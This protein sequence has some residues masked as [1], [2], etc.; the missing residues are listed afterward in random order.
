MKAPQMAVGCLGLTLALLIAFAPRAHAAAA[1]SDTPCNTSSAIANGLNTGTGFAAWTNVSG[2]FY[3]GG[4]GISGDACTSHDWGMFDSGGLTTCSRPLTAANGTNILQVGQTITNDMENGG[5]TTG[6]TEGLSLWNASGQNV[7]EMYFVGGGSFWTVVDG[8]GTLTT[9]SIPYAGSGCR[10]IFTL[11]SPTTYSL[12]VNVPVGSTKYGPFTGSL[13]SPSGGQG[14]TQMRWFTSNIGG[15][16]NL[17]VGQMNVTCPDKLSFT[18]QPVS[19]IVPTNEAALFSADNVGDSVTYQWQSSSSSN[20]TYSAI[21]GG[22]NSYSLTATNYESGLAV[23]ATTANNNNWYRCVATDACGNTATSGAAQLILSSITTPGITSQP[24][25]TTVCSNSPATF[26]VTAAGSSPGYS[27][28]QQSNAGWGSG[29]A[30][31]V[32]ASNAGSGVFLGTSTNNETSVSSFCTGFGNNDIDSPISGNALGLFGP[33]IKV[34]RNFPS[35]LSAGQWF[36]IDMDNGA[37]DTGAQN[38][39][40]LHAGP[41]NTNSILFS[42]Y[43]LG[44]QLNYKIFDGTGE[45]DTGIRFTRTGLRVQVLVGSAVGGTN[46]YSLFVLTNQCSASSNIT[47]VFSGLF[48]TN[49]T[50]GSVLLYNNDAAGGSANDLFFNNL[51]AGATYDNADNYSARNWAN[52]GNGGDLPI[53]GAN[54]SSYTINNAQS[55]NVAYYVIVTNAAAAVVSSA[56]T[57]TINGN[58]TITTSSPLTAGS[59]NVSYSQTLAASGGTSPY[60]WTQTGGTLPTGLLLG[61]NGVL[62]GTPTVPGLY[63]FMVQAQDNSSTHCTVSKNFTLIIACNVTITISPTS[64]TPTVGASYS[65]QLTASAGQSPYTYTITSGS[66]PTGL[67]MTSGGLITGTTVSDTNVSFSVTALDANGCSGIQSYNVAPGCPTIS[68]SPGGSNP[69][70]LT[71]GTAAA[72]YSQTITASGAN[73][74]FTYSK[75]AGALPT[76]LTLSSAGVLSGTPTVSGVYTFTVTATD[77]SGCTGSQNY[78]LTINCPT[79]SLSPGGSNPQVLTAGTVGTSYTQT[80]TASGAENSFTFSKTSGTL[81]TGLSLSSAGVLS[82]TPTASGTYTFT[83]TA[84]DSSGCTGTQNYSLTMNCPIITVSPATLPN[85]VFNATYSTNLTATGG[86]GSIAFVVGSGLPTGLSLS[87]AGVLSGTPSAAGTYTFTVTATDTNGCTGLTVYN[88]TVGTK[89]SIAT[90]PSA[91]AVCSGST[92]P[93]TVTASGTSIV[94]YQW[95]KVGGGWGTNNGWTLTGTTYVGSSTDN[96]DGN[97]SCSGTSFNISG[98]HDINSSSGNALGMYGTATALRTFPALTTFPV[99]VSVD[100]D[101]GN[102]D[103]GDQSGLVLQ[104]AGAASVL[105]FYFQGGGTDYLYA[106]NGG[107][108]QDTGIAFARTGLRIQWILNSSTSYTLIVIPCGGTPVQFTGT[109]SGTI[110]ALKLFDNNSGDSG[111]QFNLYFNN[112]I[113]GGYS[114]NAD[115]Y[116]T[117][118]WNTGGNLGQSPISG[119]TNASYTTP[120]LTTTNNGDQYQAVVYNNYGVAL[121]SAASLTVNANPVLSSTTPLGAATIGTAYSSTLTS[122][123]GTAPYTYGVGSGLPPGITLSSGGVLSGTPTNAG[124]YNFTVTITDSSSTLCASSTNLSITANC[125]AI[126]VGSTPS[127]LLNGSVGVSYS[128]SFSATGGNGPYTFSSTGTL[129]SGLTLTSAGTLSGTP[130]TANTY[131]FSIVATDIYGCTGSHSYNITMANCTAI[132]LSPASPTP[133]LPGGA[134]G[135]PYSQNITASGGN[136]GS[137]A[138]TSTGTLPAGL[139]LTSPNSTTATLSGTP[140]TPGTYNFNVIATDNGSGCQQAIGYTVIVS[141]PTITLSSLTSGTA[142]VAYDQTITASG[143]TGSFT[144]QKTSGTLPPGLT[145][146]TTGELHGTPTTTGSF[147]FTVQATHTTSSCTGSQSYTVAIN[148]AGVSVSITGA[149]TGAICAGTGINLTANPSGGIAPYIY[150]WTKDSVAFG[151]NTQSITDSPATGSHSYIVSV[152]DSNGCGASSSPA[153]VTV[154]SAPTIS[155]QPQP[156]NVCAGSTANFSVTAS[157]TPVL[158]SGNFAWRKRSAGWGSG[159]GWTFN[160]SGQG[161]W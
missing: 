35:S 18:T 70:S 40:S 117:P 6:N 156:T 55:N 158:T 93:F 60:T 46:T 155:A 42:F 137:F 108:P 28:F 154:N 159:N 32:T 87:S 85:E 109:Y 123:N 54:S 130:T 136:S 127:A 140:T 107:T 26:S 67:S 128:A 50:P 142:G 145:L 74:S 89:A 57:L 31:S 24:A 77:S 20:G 86:S 100:M 126:T 79:I 33:V 110:A 71:A 75:S 38:G 5:I 146:E 102:V 56:A 45:H 83:V 133:G 37:V 121:S 157:A 76:G 90:Q 29:N 78:S 23:V 113:V 19:E 81:P 51:V 138:F 30:W 53:S 15:G 84:T 34:A 82:G 148:C 149:P 4:S 43:F 14:I 58:P 139:T 98:Q 95:E 41:P 119:A 144:F 68:F 92:A 9:D 101:N 135:T 103:S 97:P 22:T 59:Q 112:F 105:K 52:G 153:T 36:S 160:G 116:V 120:T 122:S 150:S 91:Q 104:T 3:Y 114:D 2:S 12:T 7:F 48:E 152:T 8:A 63:N 115:N 118:G 66:L 132:T 11:T 94:N 72:S 62:S 61:T 39:F 111:S 16:N 151:S 161:R 124:V 147:G 21:S 44:G 49:G 10:V 27:W 134:V 73:N 96:E 141:C 143:L 129:P 80:I 47:N 64:L 1:A 65:Q 25:N 69:T 106:V 131:S 125:P 99:V 17:Q 88:V 13:V